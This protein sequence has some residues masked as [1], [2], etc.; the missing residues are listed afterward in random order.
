MSTLS[1]KFKERRTNSL[2][3]A[4]PLPFSFSLFPRVTKTLL[5]FTNER[6]MHVFHEN[7]C[8][9]HYGLHPNALRGVSSLV[10][11]FLEAKVA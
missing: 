9:L 4:L 11:H 3:L 8:C 1:K 10:R 5:L 2:S 7:A 6:V